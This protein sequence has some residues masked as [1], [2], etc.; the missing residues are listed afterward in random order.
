MYLGKEPPKQKGA[1]FVSHA[2]RRSARGQDCTL[3]LPGCEN[4]TS[5]TVLCHLRFF[6]VA[7]M[8]Q[9]P[10]DFC[11]VY[12]CAH[13]HNLLDKTTLWEW[14]DVL[15]ALMKTLTKHYEEGRIG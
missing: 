8:G 3:N 2:W 4:D 1:Q 11:A 6:N 15:R 14:E 13:C 7:G 5:T 10:H 12:G 9:K